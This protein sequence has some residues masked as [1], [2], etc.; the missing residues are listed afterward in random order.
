MLRLILTRHG[1]TDANVN[2]R[3][4]G[5]SDGQLNTIGR[6][7]VG[8]LGEALKNT[9]LDVIISSDMVRAQDTAAAIARYHKLPVISTSLVRE[10]NCGEWDGRPAKE[11]IEIVK[12]LTIPLSQLRPSGGETLTEVQARARSFIKDVTEK[13]PGKTVVLCSHGDFLRMVISVLMN[14]TIEEVD[15]TYRME[16]ASY[17]VF[18][19]ENGVWKMV[20]F[21][22]M[23]PQDG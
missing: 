18:D 7:E 3:L 9:H 5:Q 6:Q 19:L 10:M 17:S 21:N 4:Q 15:S 13:Y 22:L 23:P 2:H 16:N 11:F 1:Q 20:A 14:K 12:N 8:R